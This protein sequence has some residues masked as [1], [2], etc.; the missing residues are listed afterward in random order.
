MEALIFELGR[1]R[2]GLSLAS[3]REIV[4][5]VTI[6]P[7]PGAPRVVLGVINLRGD[8]VPVLD[9][10]T[11]F[12]FT[13]RVVQHTDHF[14][15]ARGGG[16]LVALLV[17]RAIRIESLTDLQLAE[18]RAATP[19][20]EYIQGIAKLSDELVLIHDLDTFLARDEGVALERALADATSIPASERGTAIRPAESS[21]QKGRG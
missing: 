20:S 12:G 6:V 19:T 9:V 18:A 21:G 15:V 1:W 14:I 8:V 2:Y 11:R 13:G 10:R 17:D 7:L 4:S 3:V 5:A 16:R